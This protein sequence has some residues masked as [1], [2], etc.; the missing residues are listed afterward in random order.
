[1]KEGQRLWTREELILTIN[2]YTKIPFGQMDHRNSQVQELAKLIDRTPGAVARRLGN[3]ASMDPVQSARGIKGLSNAGVVAENVWD[4]F[5]NNWDDAFEESEE[6]LAKY[7]HVSI[8]R[9]Y[10]LEVSDLE[11]GIDKERMV[12]TRVNQYRFR[13]LVMTNYNNTCC[14]TGIQQPELLIASHITSWSKFEN[15]RLNP[16]NGVCLN[17]LHDKAFDSGL[18]TISADDYTIHISS[19]LKKNLNKEIQD[20]FIRYEGKIINL[21]KKFLPGNKFLKIHNEIF[22]Q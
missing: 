7:K 19:L 3:F 21:P 6:L 22:K 4:E 11:K 9:L 2:L 10:N 18:I 8:E 5:Y 16:M 14:I 1:M 17:A 20:Y 12:K 13:Q 15:N